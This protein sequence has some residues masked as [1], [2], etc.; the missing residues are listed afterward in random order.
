MPFLLL[1]LHD[2]SFWILKC[3]PPSASEAQAA[4]FHKTRWWN[5]AGSKT[6]NQILKTQQWCVFFEIFSW[7]LKMVHM[8]LIIVKVFILFNCAN[9]MGLLML[10]NL[11]TATLR[12]KL[13]PH[14]TIRWKISVLLKWCTF[15]SDEQ[16]GFVW[17]EENPWKVICFHRRRQTVFTFHISKKPSN[18][19]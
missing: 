17:L 2:L 16:C 3:M 8:S 4:S 5:K 13:C 1:I 9:Q 7:I 18:Q 19:Q 12:R 6:N 15:S 11:A 10:R 14:F